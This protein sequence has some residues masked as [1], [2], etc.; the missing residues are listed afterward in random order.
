MSFMCQSCGKNP[1][2]VHIIESPCDKEKKIE[3]HICE[4]CAKEKGQLQAPVSLPQVLEGLLE[5][6][7][8]EPSGAGDLACP[9]CGMTFDQF[10]SEG[11]FGC[12]EDYEVFQKAL[13]PFLEKI[14]GSTRHTGRAPANFD[15]SL[16]IDQRLSILQKEM[17]KAIGLEDY[18][19]AAELRDRIR[20]L[21]E[22]G[23]AS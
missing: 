13:F 20:E 22:K 15:H 2:T 21:K 18:E 8:S 17:E 3:I 12:P 4:E 10:K 11:R 1:A 19:R 16:A 6:H 14:H 23:N 9:K 7:S 5:G